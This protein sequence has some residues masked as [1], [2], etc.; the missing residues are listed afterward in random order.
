MITSQKL[1]YG[2]IQDILFSEKPIEDNGTT[3]YSIKGDIV[4]FL[5]I[6]EV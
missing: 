3:L 4:T 6:E 2:E 5:F 1:L